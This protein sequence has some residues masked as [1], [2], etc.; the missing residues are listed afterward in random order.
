VK[1]FRGWW[2]TAHSSLIT[3]RSLKWFWIFPGI[4][5]SFVLRKS[6]P[7]LVFL[8]VYAIITGHWSAEEAAKTE[9]K[10]EE[11]EESDPR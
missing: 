7:Y 3:H 5:I 11:A 2:A 4:P 9:V 1:R 10:A 6:V 8:S